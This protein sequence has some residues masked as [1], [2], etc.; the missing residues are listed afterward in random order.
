[1]ITKG[2]KTVFSGAYGLADREKKAKN[3][4]YTQFRIGSMNKM[5]T[6]VAVLQLVQ[7][8]KIKLT[9]PLGEYLTDYPNKDIAT[10]VTIHHLLTHTGGT[11]DF[12]GPEF[13]K[14]RLEL[15]ALQDYV[16]LYGKRGL[17]FE[18]GSKWAYSNYGF[19]LLGV[20][21]EKVSGQSY[22]D[23][24]AEH[25]YKPADMTLTAS[26]AEDQVVPGRSVGYTH[27]REEGTKPINSAS[28]DAWQPNTN[29]LP[30]RGTSAG[31]GYSTVEDLFRFASA[32]QNHK[33]LDA[34]H[35]ELL[36][37]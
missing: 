8:G 30:Y 37:I 5:F 19:L 20:L 29:T 12:F 28:P 21:V 6:A 14:H 16:N 31:G 1:M 2:G 9:A 7:S 22:Y 35:T 26:L 4:L 36:T 11:G 27:E 18:P 13:D 24:V 23:Y 32:L 3:E 25:V 10:K 17:A 34:P 33:L 15:R